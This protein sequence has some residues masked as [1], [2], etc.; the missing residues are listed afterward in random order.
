VPQVCPRRCSQ[1]TR[2]RRRVSGGSPRLRCACRRTDPSSCW[3]R[4]ARSSRGDVAPCL[5]ASRAQPARFA[6]QAVH[7]GACHAGALALSQGLALNSRGLPGTAG[8]LCGAGCAVGSL[9]R[10]RTGPRPRA[11]AGQSG[12]HGRARARRRRARTPPRRAGRAARCWGRCRRLRAGRPRCRPWPGRAGTAPAPR[13]TDVAVATMCRLPANSAGR[14]Q[15][16][17]TIRMREGAQRACRHLERAKVSANCASLS[18]PCARRRAAQRTAAPARARQAWLRRRRCHVSCAPAPPGGPARAW[19][20]RCQS[21]CRAACPSARRASAAGATGWPPR[22]PW[23]RQTA[24]PAGGCAA[25]R[26]ISRT[27]PAV[28]GA[29]DWIKL[30]TRCARL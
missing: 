10:R 23:R 2:R 25:R 5:L 11:G 16:P 14:R 28:R 12:A 18:M 19:R 24:S 30:Q 7:S 15:G 3:S 29:H 20:R 22:T 17:R 26:P 1:A 8:A 21:P 6:V 13:S 4:P 9:P 27:I